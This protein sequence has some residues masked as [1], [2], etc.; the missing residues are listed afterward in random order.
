MVK[1]VITHSVYGQKAG[2]HRDGWWITQDTDVSAATSATT[3]TNIKA[4][5]VTTIQ[6]A[7]TQT[8]L[9]EAP[10]PGVRKEIQRITTSSGST[11]T[12]RLVSGNILSTIGSSGVAI[13]MSGAVRVVLTG[14]ST[15]LYS[16]TA[17]VPNGQITVTT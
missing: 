12:V 4:G 5:G 9:L 11:D 3:G 14:L 7:S 10:I 16:M 17:T 1:P 2:T 6:S 15:A 13:T 8:F